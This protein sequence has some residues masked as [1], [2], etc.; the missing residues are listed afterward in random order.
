MIV[1][2]IVGLILV[3]AF[4]GGI[5]QGAVK[6]LFSLVAF[7]CALWLTGLVYRIP[8]G[9]FSFLRG[10]DWENFIGFALTLAVISIVLHLVLLLPRFICNKL[11]FIKGPV[12][13]VTGGLLNLFNS[14]LGLTAF[15]LLVAAYP[16]IDWLADMMLGSSMLAWLVRLLGFI[17]VLVPS[18]SRTGALTALAS[19]LHLPP[20]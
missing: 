9:W 4:I 18:L 17:D 2:V 16:I 3:F 7:L 5:V 13:R 19:L 11:W 6:S 8:A 14:A 1:N 10:E 20:I 15:T 12:Y